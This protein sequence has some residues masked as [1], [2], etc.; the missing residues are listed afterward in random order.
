M[1]V[2]NDIDRYAASLKL[3]DERSERYFMRISGQR[4]GYD[5]EIELL[6]LSAKA[7]GADAFLKVAK[8]AQQNSFDDII[9]KQYSGFSDSPSNSRPLMENKLEIPMKQM[10]VAGQTSQ[11]QQI[12]K[13][14]APFGGFGGFM[15]VVQQQHES[16]FENK[17][18]HDKLKDEE[19]KHAEMLAKL[20]QV[21][22][23][24]REAKTKYGE[25][26]ETYRDSKNEYKDKLI[27]KERE[28]ERQRFDQE[29]KLRD[30][31]RNLKDQYN[32]LERTKN[33]ALGQLERKATVFAGISKGIEDLGTKFLGGY[34][35]EAQATDKAN[36]P[37]AGAQVQDVE[38]EPVDLSP[39]QQ[40]KKNMADKVAKF[41]MGNPMEVAKKVFAIIK[42]AAGSEENINQLH[43]LIYDT[44]GEI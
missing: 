15:G 39:G 30:L 32:T 12:D 2:K 44:N 33:E 20:G 37:F 13:H 35:Q 11:H 40:E 14:F 31:E 34:M 19:K 6:K 29:N 27:D 18:L 17:R 8:A 16:I 38:V 25:L 4:D 1:R 28:S 22:V 5:D 21:E 23:E 43:S 7:T 36:G 41:I 3:K 24:L 26:L 42:H 9:V 10:E